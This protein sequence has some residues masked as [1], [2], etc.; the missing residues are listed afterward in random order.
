MKSEMEATNRF[1][2]WRRSVLL[3]WKQ[4]SS[5][6]DVQWARRCPGAWL[7]TVLDDEEQAVYLQNLPVTEIDCIG[8]PAM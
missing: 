5:E 8:R 4:G 2:A 3:A 1:I 7:S 6:V